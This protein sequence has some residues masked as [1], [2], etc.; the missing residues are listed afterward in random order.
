MRTSPSFVVSGIL[1]TIMSMSALADSG[2]DTFRLD[3]MP[4]KNVAP[5]RPFAQGTKTLEFE[6][7]YTTPI[8]F[9]VEEFATGSVGVGYYVFDNHS[10]TLFAQGFH[11]SQAFGEST[12]AGAVFV[13]GRSILYNL[14]KFSFYIDGGGGY[15]WANAAVPIG[16]TTYNFNARAGLGLAYRLADDAYLM[17]GARYFH[18]SNAHIHGSEKNPSYDGIEYYVGLMFTFR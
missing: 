5:A 9:S 7:S 15:S 8:R 6:G 14:D 3:V 12:D 4:P 2:S 18:L 16:G 17:G 10:I 11:V 13:M 1:C